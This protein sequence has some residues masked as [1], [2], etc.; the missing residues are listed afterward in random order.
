MT[1]PASQDGGRC[2]AREAE[3]ASGLLR[4]LRGASDGSAGPKGGGGGTAARRAEPGL[5]GATGSG[6]GGCWC[7]A[8]PLPQLRA[9]AGPHPWSPDHGAEGTQSVPAGG[10]WRRAGPR[11]RRRPSGRVQASLGPLHP[12]PPCAGCR[13]S[14]D[15]WAVRTPRLCPTQGPAVSGWSPAPQ[16]GVLFPSH[17]EAA[18]G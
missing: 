16:R 2:S 14:A 17:S 9:A 4:C 5:G 3:G 11:G 18:R 6:A 12:F 8:G 7:W 15:P 1:L 13:P 10:E